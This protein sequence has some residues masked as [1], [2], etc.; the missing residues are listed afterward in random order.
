MAHWHYLVSYPYLPHA[1]ILFEWITD[2][3][4]YLYTFF[5][6][7]GNLTKT[8]CISFSSMDCNLPSKSTWRFPS[9]HLSGQ[10]RTPHPLTVEQDS[11]FVA[12]SFFYPAS[13]NQRSTQQLFSPS[14]CEETDR[15]QFC[16]IGRQTFCQH[17]GKKHLE[18]STVT[19]GR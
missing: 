3:L 16:A 8:T 11:R 10:T 14:G 12:L 7:F 2:I 18:V 4:T 17:D 15:A 19:F 6:L 1:T 9:L 5:L 13:Y